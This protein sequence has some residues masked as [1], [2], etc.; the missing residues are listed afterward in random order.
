MNEIF[1]T[2]YVLIGCCYCLRTLL[3]FEYLSCTWRSKVPPF[4]VPSARNSLMPPSLLLW[5]LSL[6]KYRLISPSLSPVY[7]ST[8]MYIY[9]RFFI[10][11]ILRYHFFLRLTY[12]LL[13]YFRLPAPTECKLYKSRNFLFYL[14]PYLTVLCSIDFLKIMSNL[15]FP[16]LSLFHVF[17]LFSFL[18]LTI[19]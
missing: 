5:P 18:I 1:F 19:F 14:F 8:H 12:K 6:L 13:V 10:P 17:L 11:L 3:F 9:I 15:F 2:W 7:S 4:A 16:F